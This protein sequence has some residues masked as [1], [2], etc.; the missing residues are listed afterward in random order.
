MSIIMLAYYLITAFLAGI[1]IWILVKEKDKTET[2][3][4]CLLLLVPILLR[5]LRIN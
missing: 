3:V 5:L 2:V 1:L 4:L